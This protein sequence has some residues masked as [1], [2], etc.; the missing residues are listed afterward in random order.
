MES[1]ALSDL[2]IKL[3]ALKHEEEVKRQ[4]KFQAQWDKNG[5]KTY[6]EIID[7]LINVKNIVYTGIGTFRYDKK[8]NCF[9]HIYQASDEYDCNFLEQVDKYDTVDDFSNL[10]HHHWFSEKDII[11]KYGYINNITKESFICF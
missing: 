5:F 4:K 8:K 7:Y 11:N 1:K 10:L 6:G 3:D 2:K 9:L